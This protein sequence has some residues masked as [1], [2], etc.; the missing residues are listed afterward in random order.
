MMAAHHREVGMGIKV[1]FVM[2]EIEGA[3]P[4]G[5]LYVAGCLRLRRRSPK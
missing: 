3:E 1:L 5:A 4:I 2:K